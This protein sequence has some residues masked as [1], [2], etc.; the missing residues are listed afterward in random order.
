[1]TDAYG[2]GP[3]D[4]PWQTG[5]E[6]PPAWAGDPA[7]ASPL[8]DLLSQLRD[9][10]LNR[11]TRRLRRLRARSD[12]LARRDPSA[13]PN[14]FAPAAAAAAGS[15]PGQRRRRRPRPG[16]G[17]DRFFLSLLLVCGM[18]LPFYNPQ[19]RLGAGAP[20]AFPADSPQ[21]ALYRALDSLSPGDLVLVGMEYGPTAAGE[22]D[23]VAD[24][25][26][27]H[28]LLRRAILVIVSRYPVTLLRAE[29]MLEETGAAGSRL[30]AQVDGGVA[31]AANR[32][33]FVTRYLAGDVVG[34]RS[35][36]MNLRAQLG[37][38][39][40]GDA[41]GLNVSQLS[42]FARV[43]VIAERPEDLRQ[44]AEQI[45]P[46][47][48][49][50]L[51]AATGQAAMPLTRPWLRVA[52]GGMMSG[53]R[54]AL[55]YD[56]QLG[57]LVVAVGPPAAPANL[58]ATS[59]DGAI[60]LAWDPPRSDGGAPL[61]A[62]TIA[63]RSA[64]ALQ[65]VSV[66]VAG[67]ATSHVLA[68][69]VNGRAYDIRLR[70][71]NRSGAGAWSNQVSAVPYTLPGAPR[72]L[73]LT[74]ADASV[75]ARWQAPQEDGGQP[76]SGYRLRWRSG[77]GDWR[78]GRA[79]AGQTAY[80]VAGLVNGAAHEFQVRAI[81]RAGEGAWSAAQTVVPGPGGP[82]PGATD[83]PADPTPDASATPGIFFA[84]VLS[85]A[86]D[87]TL[88]AAASSTAT[89]LGSVNPGDNVLVLLR[90]AGASW[91]FLQ[92]SGGLR[93]WLPAASLRLVD[94]DIVDVPQQDA[95]APTPT[96]PATPVATLPPS[97]EEP[98][99]SDAP[100]DLAGVA[101]SAAMRQAT[102][103]EASMHVGLALSMVLIALGA[104]GNMGAVAL[105][106]G[107]GR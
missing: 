88:R 44:W 45:A 10:P 20:T 66:P 69:L 49:R 48:G 19:T 92:T 80:V 36:T 42:D 30:A 53:Y 86:Q 2:Q 104:L 89:A 74:A 29:L 40:R 87:L 27:R 62:Y 43:L 14:V 39:L 28:V 84:T 105:R 3:G 72:A 68:G 26:L 33:W 4:D 41:T 70:A 11:L 103:R 25:L 9:R 100:A 83:S 95:P 54:D 90:N 15:A 5:G 73:T 75:E 93:G 65:W 50:Q 81:N 63:H 101:R 38:D 31:L 13:V 46:L 79:G 32:D 60:E 77:A 23:G 1:M 18:L 7:G 56:A 107:R 52:L 99:A 51:L 8:H 97:L 6:P 78:S 12:Q 34:L 55:T 91:L 71:A 85:G 96:T 47:A 98:A 24:V 35:L 17:G 102:Q 61:S 21:A 37:S 76:V 58:R 106:R 22:L 94:A 64:P 59:R 67:N 16:P 57:G 82:A